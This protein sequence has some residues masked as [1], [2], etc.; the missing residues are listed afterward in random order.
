MGVRDAMIMD[1][2]ITVANKIKKGADT[3][4]ISTP[5]VVL[6]SIVTKKA[7]FEIVITPE[8]TSS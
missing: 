8:T 5:I 3:I 4:T 2:L 1:E 7:Y 6:S